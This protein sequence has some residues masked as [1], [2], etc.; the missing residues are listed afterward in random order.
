MPASRTPLALVF[1]GAS[2]M[3][4]AYLALATGF[5]TAGPSLATPL[6]V[7]LGIAGLMCHG[8]AL[9]LSLRAWRKTGRTPRVA[10]F[11]A[12]LGI[13]ALAWWGV[14]AQREAAFYRNTPGVVSAEV[15]G[16]GLDLRDASGRWHVAACPGLAITETRQH[17]GLVEVPGPDG[18]VAMRV[19][20][21]T[22][23]VECL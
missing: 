10:L 17:D 3:A 20:V 9:A 14:S 18:R 7:A 22:R 15:A 21:A 1:V 5:F 8:A 4:G 12:A 2:L 23:R 16:D 6:G 13:A 19:V 11:Y